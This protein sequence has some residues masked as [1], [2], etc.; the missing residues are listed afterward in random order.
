M[1]SMELAAGS[2]ANTETDTHSASGPHV[3]KESLRGAKFRLDVDSDVAQEIRR[4]HTS[5]THDDG[6]VFQLEQAAIR[7]DYHGL[8]E[9]VRDVGLQHH[10]E[11]TAL[12]GMREAF[13]V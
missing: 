12:L 13:S 3:R 7:L 8:T 9:N 2:A 11:L 5:G 10:F 1:P 4:Q 6:I